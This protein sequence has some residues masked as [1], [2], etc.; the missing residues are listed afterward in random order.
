MVEAVRHEMEIANETVS[1]NV[2]LGV[3]DEPMKAVLNETK[4]QHSE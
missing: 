2:G 1:G 3:E 4:K